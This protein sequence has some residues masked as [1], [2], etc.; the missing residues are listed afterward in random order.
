MLA[1]NSHALPQM[2]VALNFARK[3]K[4]RVILAGNLLSPEMDQL[5]RAI[6]DRYLPGTVILHASP[7]IASI[8]RFPETMQTDADHLMP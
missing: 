8:Q 3:R 1:E 5:R 2:L 4:T 6:D 7:E